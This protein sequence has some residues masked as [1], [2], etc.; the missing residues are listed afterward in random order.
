MELVENSLKVL[1]KVGASQ[2]FLDIVRANDEPPPEFD[3]LFHSP[4]DY[5]TEDEAVEYTRG[6]L[7]PVFDDGGPTTATFYDP[8]KSIFAEICMESSE[9]TWLANWQQVLAVMVNNKIESSDSLDPQ[10]VAATGFR[11]A[12]R[13]KEFRTANAGA[14][15]DDWEKAFAQFIDTLE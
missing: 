9:E 12:E 10:F 4:C 2:I 13:L 1:A 5:F 7:I 11:Y 15:F 6:R 3:G 14:S 8:E